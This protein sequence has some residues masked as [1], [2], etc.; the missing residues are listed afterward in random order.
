ME[1]RDKVRQ[2]MHLLEEAS[3]L[4]LVAEGVRPSAPPSRRMAAGVA[5][6]VFACFLPCPGDHITEGRSKKGGAERKAL[7]LAS[8]LVAAML[9]WRDREGQGKSEGEAGRF[10]EGE[11]GEEAFF[12]CKPLGKVYDSLAGPIHQKDRPRAPASGGHRTD[13]GHSGGWNMGEG[14]QAW[15][16][17][18]GEERQGQHTGPMLYFAAAST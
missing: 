5:A 4:D 6:A 15:G 12:Q 14:P 7:D 3:K 2:A 10:C 1:A 17:R 18:K 13:S 8:A 11:S 9:Q 16:E